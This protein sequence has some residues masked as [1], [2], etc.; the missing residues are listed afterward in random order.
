M[1]VRGRNRE[2]TLQKLKKRKNMKM[3]RQISVT[4]ILKVKLNKNTREKQNCRQKC[5]TN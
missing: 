3:G 2:N 4:G 5:G 1:K